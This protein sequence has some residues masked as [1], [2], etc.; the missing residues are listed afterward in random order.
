MT[1]II[2]NLS[3]KSGDESMV[4]NNLVS[5][6]KLQTDIKSMKFMSL[7][8][9]SEHKKQLYDMERQ[10][11]NM[12]EQTVVFTERFSS[13]GWCVYDSMSFKLIEQVNAVFE[14][15]GLKAA[16]KVLI[17]Y[18]KTDVRKVVY[19]IKNSS[20][21]FAIRYTLIQQFFEDHF[22]ERYYASIPLGLIIVD[23]AVND[24]TKSKGFFAEG[25]SVDAWDCLVGCNN[26]L[27]KLK[28]IFNQKRKKTNTEVI[29]LPYRN[30]I[31]HGRDLNYAN[32][33]VSC[34]C[35]ALMFAIADWM[36]MKNSEDTRRDKFEKSI[37]KTPIRQLL[38]QIVENAQIREEI[39]AWK[40]REIIVGE[41]IPVTGTEQDYSEYPYIVEVVKML[42]AWK[43]RNYGKLSVHLQKV[44]SANLT[45]GKRAGQ[46]RKMFENKIFDTFEIL[47]VEERAC[48]LSKVVLK[49]WWLESACKK[50][51]TLIFGCAYMSDT[52]NVGVPWKN[53]GQWILMPWDIRGLYT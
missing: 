43:K 20:E 33:Y 31:L 47:E 30:G 26:S 7:F 5:L 3:I 21:A 38:K 10:L 50:E 8:M 44:F 4:D 27:K 25:T 12:I 37:N 2:L 22:A 1:N 39:A 23:G 9:N 11:N 52:R 29:T 42:S 15:E 6:E 36:Q 18:Y 48:S 14:T 32:E 35:V 19:R 16:E 41:D 34:K 17:H 24:F 49:I 53:N 13:L 51:A 46:C 40:K 28:S 45:E